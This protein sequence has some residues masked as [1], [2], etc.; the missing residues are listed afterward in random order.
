MCVGFTLFGTRKELFLPQDYS[1]RMAE[2]AKYHVEN[3]A[4]AGNYGRD[5]PPDPEVLSTR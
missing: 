3:F 2:K 4:Y 1:K 5:L